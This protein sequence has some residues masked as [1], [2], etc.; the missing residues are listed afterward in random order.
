MPQGAFR[1]SWVTAASPYGWPGGNGLQRSPYG[2][3]L[4][5]QLAGMNVWMCM[6]LPHPSMIWHLPP[7]GIL[8]LFGLANTR[9]P[10]NN[11]QLG[12]HCSAS[13]TPIGLVP[14]YVG[15]FLIGLHIDG[16]LTVQECVAS[17]TRRQA[18]GSW[19]L[20]H[21]LSSS[22]LESLPSD[23]MIRSVVDCCTVAYRCL[24]F[25]GPNLKVPHK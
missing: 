6:D 22:Q 10:S 16:S 5:A 9:G 7:T 14:K 17:W 15:V 18:H 8:A 4:A 1:S 19:S 2:R 11:L 24:T 23:A 20:R 21:H 25:S 12:S 3:Q 13:C